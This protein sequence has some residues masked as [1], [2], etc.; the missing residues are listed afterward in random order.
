MLNVFPNDP[1]EGKLSHIS[2]RIPR[3]VNEKLLDMLLTCLA[4]SQLA[5]ALYDP[6]DRLQFANPAFRNA[7]EVAPDAYPTWEEMIRNC[8]SMKKGALIDT[9]D[10]DAWIA[11]ASTRRRHSKDRA[12]EID[13]V[14]GRWLRVTESLSPD[15]W[16]L[17]IASDITRLKINEHRLE[18]DRDSAMHA[19]RTDPLTGGY[20]R[21]FIFS[22]LGELLAHAQT[23]HEP[24]SVAVI[25]LDHFKQINDTFGHLAGDRL[26]QHFVAEVQ[27]NLRHSDLLGRIGGEE[28]L[29]LFPDTQLAA[30]VQMIERLRGALSKTAALSEW[31]EVRCTF[32]GGVTDINSS[33]TVSSVFQRADQAVYS[34]K[35]SGRNQHVAISSPL[36]DDGAGV[37]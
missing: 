34:A 2:D 25:D 29:L 33:D 8:F 27:R 24:L 26:L 4:G 1:E 32:S 7:Y 15:G 10:I 11:N 9:D 22:R 13:L 6:E 17:L 36:C 21:R 16:L 30:A 35:Q 20:N 19:A 12:F 14:D 37:Q 28:F 23:T 5:V 3:E 31:P 18:Q